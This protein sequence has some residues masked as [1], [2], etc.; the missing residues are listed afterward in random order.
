MA[1]KIRE[2]VQQYHEGN[3]SRRE[4]TYKAMAFTGSLAAATV[5]ADALFA[6]AAY[7][8]QVDAND[9][10]LKSGDVQFP[11][12][13]GNVFGY[14]SRPAAAGKYP[15]IVIIS[16]NQ[17][18]GDHFR[19]VARR[20][21]KEGYIALVPDIF[22]RHGGT[23]KVNPKGTG[24]SNFP[25]LAPDEAVAE[26]INAG[27]SYLKTLPEVRGDRL[28]IT[29]FCW[30]GGQAYLNTTQ[31]RG[32]R[33]AVIFYGETPKPLELLERIEAPVLAH[34]AERDERITGAVPQ[35]E[36]AMKKYN[37][38]YEYKIYAGAQHAFFHD[39]RPDR[40]HPEAAKEAWSR[41]LAFFKKHLQS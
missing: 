34:Y 36:A 39:Q 32:L 17:G 38:S 25:E 22:S 4:F 29:G 30:G 35:T 31:V 5:F 6:P 40:Y 19:D 15:A 24:V 28:G 21:A 33:A 12:Q 9:P 16:D 41:T 3:I 10:G 7:G 27:Y 23:A 1:E 18:L 13:K 37:K 14:L 2:L 11:G 20:Y 8:A 26:Y